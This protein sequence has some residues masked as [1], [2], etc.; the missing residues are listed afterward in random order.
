MSIAVV[1]AAW[2][3][4]IRCDGPLPAALVGTLLALAQMIV[5]PALIA[6]SVLAIRKVSLP[7][8]AVFFLATNVFI[9]WTVGIIV[10]GFKVAKFSSALG[11][12]LITGIAGFFIHTSLKTRLASRNPL[13][14]PV[15][16]EA[17]AQD[18]MKQ[19]KGRVIR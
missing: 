3:T 15:E 10:P 4:D 6:A 16:P 7:L 19:A 5:R 8:I 9:F 14:P 2:L 13:V 12:S 11:G 18:A 1:V 17:P